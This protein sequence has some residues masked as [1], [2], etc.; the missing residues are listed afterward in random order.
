MRSVTRSAIVLPSW[1]RR[2]AACDYARSAIPTAVFIRSPP[3]PSDSWKKRVAV[4]RS[5][6]NPATRRPPISPRGRKPCR[7]TIAMPFRMVSAGRFQITFDRSNRAQGELTA[8]Q[9]R[10]TASGMRVYNRYWRLQGRPSGP[11][12]SAAGGRSDATRGLCRAQMS[13]EFS[14]VSRASRFASLNQSQGISAENNP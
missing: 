5:M 8:A 9:T 10:L 2:R 7:G 12:W 6:S 13:R 1:N 14:S 3:K 11:A 4:L